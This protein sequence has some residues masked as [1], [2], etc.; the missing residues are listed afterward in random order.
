MLPHYRTKNGHMNW[1]M[2]LAYVYRV[3]DAHLGQIKISSR[4]GEYTSVMLML[5]TVE[6]EIR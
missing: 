4:K 3:V 5:P 1:G 6:K 2:G